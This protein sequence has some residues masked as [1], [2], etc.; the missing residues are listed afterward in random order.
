MKKT[1]LTVF[2][3]LCFVT[4]LFVACSEKGDKDGNRDRDDK[5]ESETEEL[6]D[7]E[8]LDLSQ[9]VMERVLLAE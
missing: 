6:K 4:V 3:V 8:G 9:M 7:S 1:F 2:L 5:T